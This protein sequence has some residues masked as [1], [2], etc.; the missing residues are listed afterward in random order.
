MKKEIFQG[1]VKEVRPV[2]KNLSFLVLTP[3]DSPESEAEVPI[4]MAIDSSPEYLWGGRVVQIEKIETGWW[5][6]KNVE[7]KVSEENFEYSVKMPASL[8]K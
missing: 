2:N 8:V 3:F 5:L 6:W 7:E 4:H 1:F